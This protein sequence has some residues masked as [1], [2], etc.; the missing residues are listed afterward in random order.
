MVA[1][2]ANL[3]T[4]DDSPVASCFVCNSNTD[5]ECKDPFGS[6]E[7][8]VEKCTGGEKFCRKIVQT[9]NGESTIVRQCAKE[10]Y[11]ENYEG[12]YKTAG[13]ATQ[14]IC[15]CKS[16]DGKPCNSG[17]TMR[18]SIFTI[19]SVLIAAFVLV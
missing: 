3:V 15:T 18:Q 19:F 17:I 10:L 4:A 11:K 6:A 2:A 1:I 8:F 5:L 9:V 14:H 7:K 16:A 12:C 13:K